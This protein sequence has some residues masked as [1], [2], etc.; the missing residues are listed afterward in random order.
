MVGA[1]VGTADVAQLCGV[2]VRRAGLTK[3]L[4]QPNI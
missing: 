2:A 3:P 4:H 1:A